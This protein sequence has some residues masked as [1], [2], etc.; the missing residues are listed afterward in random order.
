M[1]HC[2]TIWNDSVLLATILWP[3]QTVRS[4]CWSW[5]FNVIRPEPTDKRF[6]S[7]YLQIKFL[8]SRK[9]HSNTFWLHKIFFCW[10][11]VI[12]MFKKKLKTKKNLSEIFN[13]EPPRQ[14][15]QAKKTSISWK[16]IDIT[17]SR[18]SGSGCG[19]GVIIIFLKLFFFKFPD[20]VH[21]CTL[22]PVAAGNRR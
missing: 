2:H 5:M 7:A 22:A 1:T 14:A 10:S 8:F 12:M 3:Q 16:I 6:N 9:F 18:K 17:H 4:S 11:Q 15:R 13:W 20:F 21:R 19:S